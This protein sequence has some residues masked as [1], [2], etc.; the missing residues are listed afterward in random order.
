MVV[1]V[2]HHARRWGIVNVA[3]GNAVAYTGNPYTGA[4]RAFYAVKVVNAAIFDVVVAWFQRKPVAS[5]DQKAS[6]A[7]I[8]YFTVN[9]PIVFSC[10]PVKNGMVIHVLNQTANR[11]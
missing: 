3:I 6:G 5:A 11:S 1:A 9:N 8:V 7:C 2:Q 10:F 4:V